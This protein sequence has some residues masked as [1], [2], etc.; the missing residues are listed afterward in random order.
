PGLADVRT[1]LR[2][3]RPVLQAA[4]PTIILLSIA[5]V[6]LVGTDTAVDVAL[7]VNAAILF[8]WGFAVGRRH[9]VGSARAAGIGAVC[10]ALGVAL[11]LLKLALH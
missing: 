4:W 2:H 11:V 6:G 9:G 3:E 5:G 10:C 7:G 8:A 1:A